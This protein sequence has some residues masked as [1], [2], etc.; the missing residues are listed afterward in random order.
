MCDLLKVYKIMDILAGMFVY[1][2]RYVACCHM[3]RE[4]DYAGSQHKSLL[5]QC[6]LSWCM[7]F[8][9]GSQVVILDVVSPDTCV[10]QTG[11]GRLLEGMQE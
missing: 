10:C 3:V 5:T 6:W 7:L 4:N 8:C 2:C 1:I 11:E 9:I